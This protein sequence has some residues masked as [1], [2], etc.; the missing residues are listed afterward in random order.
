MPTMSHHPNSPISTP[1]P[2]VS[3]VQLTAASQSSPEQLQFNQLTQRIIEQK[4]ELAQ[5]HAAINQY[6]QKYHADFVPLLSDYDNIRTKLALRLDASYIEKTLSKKDQEKIAHLIIEL[7]TSILERQDHP[8]LQLLIE[9]YSDSSEVPTDEV[10]AITPAEQMIDFNDEAAVLRYMEEQEQEW[11]RQSQEREQLAR[12]RKKK[13]KLGAKQKAIENER[14]QS[15]VSIREVYRKLASALHPDREPD[16][17]ERHRKTELM[18][19]VNTAY[20]KKDLLQLFELQLEIEQIKPDQFEQLNAE[21]LIH[22]LHVLNQQSD[23][24]QHEINHLQKTA[25]SSTD[26]SKKGVS[27]KRK[28]EHLLRELKRQIT[29]LENEIHSIKDYLHLFED[30]KMIKSMLKDFQLPSIE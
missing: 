29:Q 22:Y 7:C 19:R 30:V 17:Q 3:A 2:I 12:E 10:A 20:D 18:K 1:S 14:I 13:S 21:K 9:K 6:Q 4:Q 15:S 11:S 8:E 24:L 23:D 16:E 28:P 26:H 5:W 25:F 27:P